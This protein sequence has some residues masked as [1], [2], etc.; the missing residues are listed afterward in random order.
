MLG[1]LVA[2]LDRPGVVEGVLAELPEGLARRLE[3]RAADCGMTI[4]EFATG[5]VREF[6]DRADDDLW[7]QLL[8][9][10]RKAEDDPGFEAI[11]TILGWVV[12]PAEGGAG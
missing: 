10:M 2:R 5:A 4:T 3:Q 12:T 7:F 8:T 11:K 1:D 9:R 6:L